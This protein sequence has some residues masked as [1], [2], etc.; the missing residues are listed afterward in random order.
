MLAAVERALEGEPFVAI[1]V[2]SPKFPTERDPG[3]VREAVRRYGVT[4]PVVVDS[5]MRIWSEFGVR[6]WPTLVLLDAD[7]TVAGAASGE[8]D[9][10]ALLRAVRRLLAHGRARGALSDAPLPLRREPAPPGSLAYPGKVV[11]GAHRV[12]VADTGHDQVV[13]CDP[14][15]VER[16][17]IGSGEPGHAD[18]GFERAR[19]HHPNGLAL[20]GDT[21][22]VAD[23]GTHTIR[24]AD[25]AARTVVTVAGTG[26]MGRGP[27]AGGHTASTPL[28]SPWDIAWDG[29][30]LYVAMAGAHQIWTYDPARE[31]IRP[32]AGT[33]REVR[34]D[35]P[36]AKAS[37]AQPSGLALAGGTLYVADSEISSVRAIEDLYASPSVRTVAGSGDLFGFGDRDGTGERALLQH[38]IGIAWGEGA[39]WLADTFNHKVKRID[40]ATGEC[41][42]AFGDGTP[43]R[44][45]EVV[46]GAPLAAATASGP[47]FFEPE[48]IW[49]R[50]GDLLVADTNN[51]R[52]LALDRATGARRVLVGG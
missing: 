36:A 39:L 42:T 23:T 33:G 22:W 18:G 41:A 38:P 32:F 9:E 3:L 49:V 40:A 1:G 46:A 2:H 44:L 31:E 30:S 7:G 12:V 47:A 50:A 15:G 11:A 10:E 43:E 8:P 25:L 45:P 52:V 20:A 24:R 34:G 21:L 28:R 48:G 37:F 26:E 29:R 27:W 17:R 35:G 19:L 14:D 4:H 16:D 51:H 5:G 13:I 6:A